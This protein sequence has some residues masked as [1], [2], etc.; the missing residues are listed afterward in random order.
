MEIHKIQKTGDM[1]YLYLPT[2]WCKE[3]RIAAASKV[4][5]SRG[6]G[7]SLIITPKLIEK[8]HKKLQLSLNEDNLDIINKL[9]VAC[10]INPIDS[11]IINLEKALD[12]RKLL[13]QKRLL[14]VEMMEIEE[15]RI[16]C[17]SSI[18]AGEPDILLKTMVNKIKNMLII[19]AKNYNEEIIQRYEEEIDK[20]RLLIDKSVISAI[21][22]K[23]ETNIKTINL[24]YI[25]LIAKDLERM[26]DHLILVDSK[27]KN[28]LAN[29]AE[30]MSSLKEV[31]DL[32]IDPEKRLNYN[33]VIK[34]VSNVFR[35]KDEKIDDIDTYHKTRVKHYFGSI[36]EVLM[37][38]A[39]TNE[40]D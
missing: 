11:F 9:V 2:S 7:G 1:H 35:I 27:E 22:F 37:D 23:R 4:S 8:K 21:T 25:A 18:N 6:S 15:K 29:I 16:T 39:V 40:A 10:Y 30:I 5:I 20:N 17:E 31:V 12:Q 38:W 32:A 24:H 13:D 34:F 14:S 36:S 33:D 3:H 19:M 28:F 26:V